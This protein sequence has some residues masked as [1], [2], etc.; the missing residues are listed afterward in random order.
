VLVR[1]AIYTPPWIVNNGLVPEVFRQS[2]IQGRNRSRATHD[3]QSQNMKI[4][5]HA[6]TGFPKQF[7]LLV[8]RPLAER[9]TQ[10]T[11]SFQFH[12]VQADFLDL[13]QFR[14]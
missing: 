7:L 12:Q 9:G 5:G 1:I 10:P 3:R 11:S 8:E 6:R 13:H 4:V 2:S 14:L